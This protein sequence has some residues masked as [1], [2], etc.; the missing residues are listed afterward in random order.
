MADAASGWR[1]RQDVL[2]PI[3]EDVLDHLVIVPPEWQRH[4][5]GALREEQSLSHVVV[6]IHELRRLEKLLLCKPEHRGVELAAPC[7]GSFQRVPDR[8]SQGR[9]L[10]F[11][12]EEVVLCPQLYGPRCQ[13]D[14]IQAGQDHHRQVRRPGV[15]AREGLEILAV[16]KYEVEEDYI[17]VA[18]SPY[19]IESVAKFTSGVNVEAGC[20]RFG[21]ELLQHLDV[22]GIVLDEQDLYPILGHRYEPSCRVL[23]GF[24]RGAGGDLYQPCKKNETCA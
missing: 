6:K 19:P 24:S 4:D 15:Y 22:D 23:F 8:T 11:R 7:S 16:G 5:L 20:G 21:Q 13:V 12:F 18:V 1:H 9:A 2:H 14:V 3:T 17:H 10:Q